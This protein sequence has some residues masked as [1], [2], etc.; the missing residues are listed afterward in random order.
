MSCHTFFGKKKMQAHIFDQKAINMNTD[1]FFINDSNYHDAFLLQKCK[2]H[3]IIIMI[4]F[5]RSLEIDKHV[6]IKQAVF[7]IFTGSLYAILG[8]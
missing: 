2:F 4:I 6:P 8:Q 1:I 7:N 3:Y 5:I